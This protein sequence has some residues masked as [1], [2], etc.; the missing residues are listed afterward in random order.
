[1]LHLNPNIQVS[2]GHFHCI[3]NTPILLQEMLRVVEMIC[4]LF[5]LSFFIK[6]FN[7]HLQTFLYFF[8]YDFLLQCKCGVGN[9]LVL[10]HRHHLPSS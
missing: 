7:C 5:F 6:L 4:L 3:S 8:T 1:M 10:I 2:L 9:M